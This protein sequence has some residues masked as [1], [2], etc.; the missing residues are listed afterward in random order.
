MMTLHGSIT[1][2]DTGEKGGKAV[3][4][5]DILHCGARTTNPETQT[6]GRR[7]EQP[8][9]RS[10]T[11]ARAQGEGLSFVTK[12]HPTA[13]EGRTSLVPGLSVI[14][15]RVRSVFSPC[16]FSVVDAV[17]RPGVMSD[18]PARDHHHADDPLH[19]LRR[20]VPA[21]AML[22]EVVRA[23]VLEVRPGDVVEHPAL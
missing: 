4:N 14:A 17:T 2:L 8:T 16:W 11:A 22:G 13:V 7:P 21:G 10:R 1:I 23:R 6:E 15:E 12:V 19:S 18:G 5:E 20:A 9:N 3:K